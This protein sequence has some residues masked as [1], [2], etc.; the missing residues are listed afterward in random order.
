MIALVLLAAITGNVI[1]PDGAPIAKARVMAYRAE[2]EIDKLRRE[3]AKKER[4]VLAAA[5]TDDSGAFK[6][7]APDGIVEV[8]VDDA[9]PLLVP[10][11]EQGITIVRSGSVVRSSQDGI[12]VHGKVVDA[13]NKPVAHATVIAEEIALAT[14]GDDGRFTLAHVPR[15][16]PLRAIGDR[17]AGYANARA[18]EITIHL[19]RQQQISGVVRDEAKKP[20][21]GVVI[22]AIQRNMMRDYASPGDAVSDAKGAFTLFVGSADEVLVMANAG[23]YVQATLNANDVTLQ[24]LVTVDGI[25]RDDHD[26]PVA[27][28][29]V[30]FIEERSRPVEQFGRGG[31]TTNANGR[32]RLHV[33][34]GARGTIDATRR[35]LPGGSSESITV[36]AAGKHDIVV[37]LRP[38]IEVKGVVSDSHG[39]PL[40]GVAIRRPTDAVQP[41]MEAQESWATTADDGTFSVHVEPGGAGLVFAKKGYVEAAK[42]FEAK[43]SMQPL[44]VALKDAAIVRGI[45]VNKDGTPVPEEPLGTEKLEAMVVTKSDGT[46]Q[47]DFPT[48]GTYTIETTMSSHKYVV[49]APSS[50]V[51][52]VLDT[53]LS[54]HGH[55]V[56]AATHEPVEQFSVKTEQHHSFDG[57]N[58][59]DN[60][61]G[62]FVV[63]GLEPGP[64]TVI[65]QADP[66]VT[67]SVQAEAGQ[68]DALEVALER[69]LPLRGRVHDAE[70]QPID[71]VS[72][73]A[74]RPTSTEADGTFALDGF[75]PDEQV[76]LTFSKKG[77]L[78]HEQRVR[79]TKD[80]A[81]ID[82]VLGRGLTVKGHVVDTSGKPVA[83]I[84]VSASSAAHGASSREEK[85]DSS[86]AFVLDAMLPARYDFTAGDEG[87]ALHGSLRDVDVEQVHDV[88][89][90]VES[91]PSGTIAGRIVGMKSGAIMSMLDVETTD[92]D[93][94]RGEIK[95]DNTFRVEH[96]PAGMA[97]VAAN[98]GT[99]TGVRRTRKVTVEVVADS[100]ANVELHLD[101]QRTL[102][103]RVTRN[104]HAV[105][106]AEVTLSGSDNASGTTGDDGSYELRADPGRYRVTVE[107]LPWSG[108]VDVEHTSVFDIDIQ[109]FI[110]HA[111]VLDGDSGAPIAEATIEAHGNERTTE[112]NGRADVEVLR[113]E[114]L[115][116]IAS[117]PGYANATADAIEGDVVLRLVHSAGAV[118]RIVDARDG[119]TLSGYAVARDAAGHVIA[120]AREAG[121]DGT[122]LLPLAPGEYR[123]SASA[124]GYG[125]ETVR[126]VVPSNEVRIALPR[127]GQLLL[128]SNEDVHGTAR[129]LLPDGDMYV[130]CWCSGI[131]DIQIDGRMTKV[132]AV[133]P[134]S[135]TLEVTP[136]GG[137]PRR[138][139]V[140]VIQGENVTVQI[141]G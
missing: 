39:K 108:N 83:G 67:T 85:S 97:T 126:A 107:G 11:D 131:A 96:V 77:W 65:V 73:R 75:A 51:R 30:W 134:G 27:G 2:S 56:D 101:E 111:L 124:E 21:A 34:P 25:V 92:G 118:V 49:H 94:F 14:T 123:F 74:E 61:A 90:R 121:A 13:N 42:D 136:F 19:R 31:E 54:I 87:S 100:I 7:D 125:S 59:D 46:F 132:D 44:H 41:F 127:G 38:S 110:T 105:P 58:V 133:S 115:T 45:L 114:K 129:L 69:G 84:A 47:L 62:E 139:P 37:K 98:I 22:Y 88:T 109:S 12:D 60:G 8:D 81:P 63:N 16:T 135:Y 53:G 113:G 52:L 117:K 93:S 138:Y 1:G 55:V 106:H 40:G 57:G 112:A 48:P 6:L 76:T 72:V 24:R 4:A 70:G 32:F 120:S 103:G 137:K 140:T 26:K 102:R 116:L 68:A 122:S 66:Y 99:M 86:G 23:P 3:S 17:S 29:S 82:V 5:T 28:A 78:D 33:R 20:V 64:V 141:D 36:P 130:R 104:G 15:D 35:G 80:A 128:R 9:E 50:D 10:F 89:I 18:G 119:R 79:V 91:R 71:G 43:S 95:P